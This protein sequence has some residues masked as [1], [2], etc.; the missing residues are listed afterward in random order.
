MPKTQLTDISIRSLKPPEKGQVTYWDNSLSGFGMRVSQG[1]AKIFV[2]V[3]GA[4]RRRTSMGRYPV[5][6]LSEARI[7]A[8]RLLAEFTLGKTKP[9]SITF[10]AAQIRFLEACRQKNRPSG[11]RAG[12]HTPLTA[13]FS[14]F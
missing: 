13:P 14:A 5:I 3:H 4:N 7:E 8:K 12:L 2:I 9:V 11:N 1:G 10:E 6:K